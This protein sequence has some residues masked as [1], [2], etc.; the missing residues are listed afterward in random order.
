MRKKIILIVI[1][2]ILIVA[3]TAIYLFANRKYTYT[4][5]AANWHRKSTFTLCEVEIADLMNDIFYP[6]DEQLFLKQI[7]SKENYVGQKNIPVEGVKDNICDIFYYDNGLF[8]LMN[9]APG[10]YQLR[11]CSTWFWKIDSDRI[12]SS[13]WYPSPGDYYPDD[14][15]DA[16][17]IKSDFDLV[18]GEF[19][20]C[21]ESFYLYLQYPEVDIDRDNKIIRCRV[22]SGPL[23]KTLTESYVE[24]DFVN[25]TV[26]CTLGDDAKCD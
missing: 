10:A 4:V 24:I 19:D 13:Y 25:K 20:S 6:Q 12:N 17:S 7:R 9:W 22:Y 8:A 11:S 18:F 16:E 2:L 26:V 14:S 21:C 1:P 3:G 5:K 15:V 23:A